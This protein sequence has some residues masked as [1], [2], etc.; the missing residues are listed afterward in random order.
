MQRAVWP[1][2]D[3]VGLHSVIQAC[4]ETPRAGVLEM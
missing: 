3:T 1:T 2:T 4:A